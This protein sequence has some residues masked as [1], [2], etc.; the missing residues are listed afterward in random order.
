M[1]LAMGIKKSDL[2]TNSAD[3]VFLCTKCTI[4]KPNS[5]FPKRIGCRRIREYSSICKVCTDKRNKVWISNNKDKRAIISKRYNLA[6]PGKRRQIHLKNKLNKPIQYILRTA[7]CNARKR[8]MEFNIT[9]QDI[10][11]QLFIQNN[12]CF[13]TDDK[14]DMILGNDNSISIDRIN[15]DIGYI[16]S[17]IVLCKYRANIMKNNASLTELYEFCE[18]VLKNRKIN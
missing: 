12:K 17:N 1:V 10:E 5:D 13:Y 14:L 7:K 3:F 11:N 16:K 4:N 18:K 15:S 9:L 8:M 2:N 6:N